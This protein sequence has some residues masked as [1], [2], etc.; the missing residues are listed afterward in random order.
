MKISRCGEIV[1]AWLRA[2]SINAVTTTTRSIGKKCCH[3]AKRFIPQPL[4]EHGAEPSVERIAC[5]CR[6]ICEAASAS[7]GATNL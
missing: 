7:R 1:S 6:Q 4:T 3:G 2:C 5:D